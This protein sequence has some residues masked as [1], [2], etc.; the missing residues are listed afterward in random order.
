MPRGA[1]GVV[2]RAVVIGVD[3]IEA[4]AEPA[5]AVGLWEA[6]EP[7]IIG[8]SLFEPGPLPRLQIGGGQLRGQLGLP[9][10]NKAQ[11]PLAVLLEADRVVGS[12]RQR[13]GRG[14]IRAGGL[15]GLAGNYIL[16]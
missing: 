12:S 6:G 4:R 10:L 2:D 3:L 13:G 1:F 8:L 5:V 11:P 9:A 16:D 14:L 15:C 7:V